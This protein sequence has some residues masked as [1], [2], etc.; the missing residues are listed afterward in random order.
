MREIA[1]AQRH[2]QTA[3]RASAASAVI[4]LRR[5]VRTSDKRRLRLQRASGEARRRGK[6]DFRP[7]LARS[8]GA[9]GAFKDRF[10]PA[11]SSLVGFQGA[12]ERTARQASPRPGRANLGRM[13]R[14]KAGPH[15]CP[16]P[17]LLVLRRKFG[18]EPFSSLYLADA[19]VGDATEIEIAAMLAH[20]GD[21]GMIERPARS[22]KDSR[23]SPFSLNFT[24][25]PAVEIGKQPFVERVHA[26][27][28][29]FRNAG[30]LPGQIER[31]AAHSRPAPASKLPSEA[32]LMLS[33]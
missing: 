21:H 18:S 2:R 13:F 26:W 12:V 22:H 23:I 33:G 9:C 11:S 19:I 17:T 20:R 32:R 10:P 6:A 25:Q 31:G 4:G 7:S 1:P 3:I 27:P 29:V 28:C 5:T 8:S 30:H 14:V 15:H 24:T 16:L